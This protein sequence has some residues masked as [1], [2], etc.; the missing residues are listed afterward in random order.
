MLW[1][2]DGY[3]RVL[4]KGT[5]NIR[6]DITPE[7][8][9]PHISEEGEFLQSCHQRLVSFVTKERPSLVM[10]FPGDPNKALRP[11]SERAE[12]LGLKL[13]D[14]GCPKDTIRSLGALA[15]YDLAMLI[16]K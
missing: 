5:G 8:E 9:V 13:L 15:L 1:E 6:G 2:A 3:W 10:F 4:Q 7:V 16:G 14:K 12:N 11:Y